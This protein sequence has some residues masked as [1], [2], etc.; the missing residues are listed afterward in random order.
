MPS[1][2]IMSLR[3]QHVIVTMSNLATMY[4]SNAGSGGPGPGLY[5]ENVHRLTKEDLESIARATDKYEREK[6]GPM[7]QEG[8]RRSFQTSSASSLQSSAAPGP[9]PVIRR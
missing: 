2:V 4:R 9:P 7:H 1:Q 3:S 6:L 5:T 8:L